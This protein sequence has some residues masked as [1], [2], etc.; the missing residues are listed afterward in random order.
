MGVGI[1]LLYQKLKELERPEAPTAHMR[2]DELSQFSLST[3]LWDE[4]GLN[5]QTVKQ[6]ELGYDIIKD[7]MTVPVR[8]INGELLGVVRRYMDPDMKNRYRYPKGFHK[9]EHLFGSWLVAEDDDIHTVAL[10]EGAIDAMSVWQAGHP[11]MAIYGSSMSMLQ[12]QQLRL[13]G[14]NNVTLF[15]DND[16]VGQEIVKRCLGWRK[17]DKGKWHKT[18]TDLRRW[19]DVRAVDWRTTPAGIKD[20]NDLTEARIKRMLADARRI[21]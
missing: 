8:N 1:D 7:A 6:F 14:I 18:D 16:K 17:D 20:A 5:E 13:L 21:A 19:F 9:R 15:F 10:T 11:A 4:R 2:E 12:V 3:T